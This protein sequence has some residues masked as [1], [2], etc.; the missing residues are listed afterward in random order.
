MYKFVARFWS[1]SLSQQ[2]STSTRNHEEELSVL[3]AP[4]SSTQA[5]FLRSDGDEIDLERPSKSTDDSSPCSILPRLSHQR[6]T[7][8]ATTK[9]RVDDS[10]TSECVHLDIRSNNCYDALRANPMAAASEDIP[11]ADETDITETKRFL[12][13][14][15]SSCEQHRAESGT[16]CGRLGRSIAVRASFVV[17]SPSLWKHDTAAADD[18]SDRQEVVFAGVNSRS[19]ERSSARR[20]FRRES[21]FRGANGEHSSR[22]SAKDRRLLQMI[23]VIFLSFLVCYLPI[24][25]TK[26]FRDAV[27]WRGLNIAGYI[28][29]YLTT[30]INPI[31]YVVMSSEYRNAYKYVLLCK[32]EQVTG[33]RRLPGLLMPG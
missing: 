28:L 27:D 25:I 14:N 18:R 20:V 24:T 8:S 7:N 4:S 21:R 9:S 26:L 22:M 19:P 31:I 2:R 29:I 1:R 12:N 15:Q 13:R 23:L 3:C 16:S 11:F 17:K 32:R 10:A 33:K 30:C 5:I 6:E